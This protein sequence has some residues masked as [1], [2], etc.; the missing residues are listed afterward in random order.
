MAYKEMNVAPTSEGGE[1]GKAFE[2]SLNLAAPGN[3]DSI[4]I[5]DDISSI[6]V[7][8]I[9]DGAA[10]AKVQTTVDDVS[11]VKAGTETWIDWDFG[12]VLANQA[13]VF[14]PVTAIRLVQAGAGAT[15]LRI[16]AQ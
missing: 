7:L 10:S 15:G 1:K 13:D 4:L 16:R 5:P 14:Y 11:I 8:A 12:A 3:S 9:S 6:S 2:Y